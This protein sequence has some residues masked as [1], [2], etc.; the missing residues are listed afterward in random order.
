MT[1]LRVR[2]L[3]SIGFSWGKRKGDDS[4]NERYGE[5]VDYKTQVRSHNKHHVLSMAD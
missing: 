4:W 2:L 5:L 1:D 3:E